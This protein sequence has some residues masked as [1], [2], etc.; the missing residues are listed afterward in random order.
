MRNALKIDLI[1]VGLALGGSLAGCAATPTSESTGAYIDDATI[2][3]KV[4]SAI[5]ADAGLKVFEIHV[6]TV[7]DVVE[8]SG[9]VDSPATIARA[10][11]IAA[12]VP[13][14]RSVRNDL[15]VK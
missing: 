11:T 15:Q 2:T 3:T 4:K 10:T 6:A 5:L 7:N 13:G 1:I 8:L 14:V 12:G 9:F